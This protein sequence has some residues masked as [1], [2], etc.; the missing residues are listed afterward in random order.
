MDL[1]IAHAL[2]ALLAHHD[3]IEDPLS[4]YASASEVLFALTLALLFVLASTRR[5]AVVAAIAAPAA[6]IVGA[7]IAMLVHR[8]RPFVA[9]P[10][11]IHGFIPH[12]ADSGFPSDH[13]TAAF[14][15]ATAIAIYH[16]RIGAVL[17]AAATTLAIARVAVGIHWPTDVL[18]GALIGVAGAAAAALAWRRVEVSGLVPAPVRRA[19]GPA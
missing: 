18:A 16:R 14:A 6:L 8:A 3:G 17:L 12:A 7:L 11:E 5:S 9:D 2:N 10:G 4:W 15:I 1:T 19:L 13:A